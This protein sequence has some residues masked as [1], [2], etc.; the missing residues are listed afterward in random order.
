V[1]KWEG[2]ALI[3]ELRALRLASRIWD[4]DLQEAIL[5]RL[6]SCEIV[7]T[8]ASLYCVPT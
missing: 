2:C 7:G 1:A 5:L 8:P 3:F 4:L 6:P